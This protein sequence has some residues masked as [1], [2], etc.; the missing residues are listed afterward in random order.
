MT[1]NQL[2]RKLLKKNSNMNDF[3]LR[4]TFNPD[5]VRSAIDRYVGTKK[6]PRADSVTHDILQALSDEIGKAVAIGFTPKPKGK[7]HGKTKTNTI[8]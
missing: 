5:T 4:H 8:A 2:R 7:T 3:A 1:K 6:Q